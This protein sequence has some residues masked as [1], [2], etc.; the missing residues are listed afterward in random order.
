MNKY[1]TFLFLLFITT[2]SFSQNPCPGTPTVNYAGKTYQTVQIGTHCWLKENLDVGTRI[3]GLTEQ[4]NNSI[5]EKYCYNDD[6]A[7]CTTYGGL[8]QWAEAVQYQNGATDSTSP[9]P[10][11]T[12]NVQGVCPSGWHIPTNDE[13]TT[14][15]AAVNND[16]NKLKTN[17]QGSGSGVSTNTRGF[18]ALLSGYRSDD[19]AFSNLG[20]DGYFWSFS[21]YDATNTSSMNLN[22]DDSYVYQGG[23]PKVLGFSV[24]CVKD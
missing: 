17:G 8:Y 22:D 11:F 5:I 23:S 10:A 3:N 14:L 19:G 2:Y 24:R 15:K 1:Y 16:G 9:N 18:S 12:G 7:I 6:T 21:E 20:S 4:T 13:F